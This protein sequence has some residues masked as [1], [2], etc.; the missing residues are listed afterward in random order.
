MWKKERKEGKKVEETEGRRW[1]QRGSGELYTATKLIAKQDR[2]LTEYEA[3]GLESLFMSQI[4]QTVCSLHLLEGTAAE[5]SETVD[6][7]ENGDD[8]KYADKA[9][10]DYCYGERIN[11]T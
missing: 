6:H 4:R 2:Q 9:D 5:H 1:D 7:E 8:E 11:V 10:G 3:I